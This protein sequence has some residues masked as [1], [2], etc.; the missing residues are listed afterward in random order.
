MKLILIA[1]AFVPLAVFSQKDSVVVYEGSG[2][3]EN[4]ILDLS[5]RNL[6]EI[7][8]RAVN[9]DIEVLIL[10]NNN[11]SELPDWL[12]NLPKLR[13]LSARNNNLQNVD[14]LMYCE[15]LEELYLSGNKRLNDLPNLARCKKLRVVDVINTGIHDLPVR[16]RGMENIGYFKYSQ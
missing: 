13:S 15:N 7:P 16:I 10:D 8:A 5:N 9:N 1:L 11:I 2:A 14:I 6:K 4:R 12:M 3:F